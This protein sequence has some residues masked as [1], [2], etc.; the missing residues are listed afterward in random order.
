MINY[1][2][3]GAAGN[4]FFNVVRDSTALLNGDAAS[5]RTRC[6]ISATDVGAGNAGTATPMI[7][8]SPSTT[9]ATT[10][11]IQWKVQSGTTA[12]VNSEYQ[13]SDDSNADR[14]G[15]SIIVR[16]ISV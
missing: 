10:Y 13:D 16:E 14:M 6:T 5:S 2:Q 9:S 12:Y 11:K 15:S 8:D 7:L 3:N 4:T 1:G